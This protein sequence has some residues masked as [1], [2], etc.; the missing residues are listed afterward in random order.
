MQDREADSDRLSDVR[1]HR[2][3]GVDVDSEVAHNG[4]W[5]AVVGAYSDW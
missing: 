1:P 5:L 4:N 3:I 2:H